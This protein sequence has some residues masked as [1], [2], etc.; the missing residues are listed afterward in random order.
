[1]A[2]RRRLLPFA[3]TVVALLITAWVGY[4]LFFGDNIERAARRA[5]DCLAEADDGCLYSFLTS[6]DIR[7]YDL[8]REKFESLI[9]KYYVPAIQGA[10]WDAPACEVM[11]EQQQAICTQGL[12]QGDRPVQSVA[13]FVSKTEEGFRSPYLVS[14]ILLTVAVLKAQPKAEPIGGVRKIQA[15][16]EQAESDGP[17]LRELGINGIYRE[18]SEGLIP[19][20]EW[21]AHCTRKLQAAEAASVNA[22]SDSE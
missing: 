15:W 7:A 20:P 18:S 22:P 3:L 14:Q 6:D 8:D 10:Q 2:S 9:K 21:Q 11:A 17:K 12:R 5:S 16:L 1:M 13:V 19:W 4:N